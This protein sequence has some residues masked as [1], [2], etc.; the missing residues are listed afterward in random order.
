MLRLTDEGRPSAVS[1]AAHC[2]RQGVNNEFLPPTM[3]NVWQA[4]LNN[5]K[6][7]PIKKTYRFRKGGIMLEV[8]LIIIAWTF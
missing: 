5:I 1:P 8:V 6:R 2:Q 3:D 4:L 7:R